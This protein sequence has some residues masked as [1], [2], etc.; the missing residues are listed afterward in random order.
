MRWLALGGVAGPVLFA[1]VVA[2]LATLRPGYSHVAQFISELGASGTQ[3]AAA[4]NFAGFVPAGLLIAGSGV[5]LLRFLPRRAL[6]VGGAALLILFGV[7]I[8][9]SGLFSCDPGC[10]QGSGSAEN[11]LHNTI[12][13][14]LFL[15]LIV[16]AFLL[17]LHFRAVP[18]RRALALYSFATALAALA[19]F[20]AMVQSLEQRELTGLWQRLLLATEF[21][22]CAVLGLLRERSG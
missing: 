18:G 3:Y 5:A 22:W 12:A 1:A 14:V 7:L 8:A 11:A 21:A 2:V 17:G 13:P 20:V 19:L 4:M 10:P 16:A 6:A 15:A 9:S